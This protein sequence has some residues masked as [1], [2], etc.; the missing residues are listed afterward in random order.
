MLLSRFKKRK[1]PWAYSCGLLK[2]KFIK[3]QFILYQ[4]LNCLWRWIKIV[5]QI[6]QRCIEFWKQIKPFFLNW[7]FLIF[8]DRTN[9]PYRLGHLNRLGRP[10]R[11]SRFIRLNWSNR[12]TR[13]TQSAQSVGQIVLVD[14][15]E[16][17]RPIEL[18]GLIWA[19]DWA[20]WADRLSRLSWT[21]RLSRLDWPSR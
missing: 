14:S 5:N 21:S 18:N 2:K 9:R 11:P 8:L 7:T 16:P 12:S 15:I 13:S 1:L 19:T 17:N 20:D 3:Y 4:K 10:N 6:F